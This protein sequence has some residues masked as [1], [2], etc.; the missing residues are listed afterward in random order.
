MSGA[1]FWDKTSASEQI[2]GV[3]FRMYTDRPHSIISLLPFA[4]NWRDRPYIIQGERT[5]TFGDMAN[6]TASRARLLVACGVKS[7]DRVLILGW[8]DPDWVL[9]FWACLRAGAIPALANTWWSVDELDAALAQLR[10]TLVLADR[11]GA[12]RIP[13]GWR[14]GSWEADGNLS[15]NGADMEFGAESLPDANENDPAAIIFT[16][17]TEGRAKAVVLAHRSLLANQQM[18]LHVT[19][20]LP[21]VIDADAGDIG[22]HTG[23]LFHIGGIHALLRGVLVGNTLVFTRGRFEPG[24]ALELIE[25][26]GIVRWSAV[27]TMAMRLL[28]HPDL[29]RRNLS[30]LRAMTIGGAPV[31]AELLKRIGTLLPSVQTSI[32]T[33][34]GLSENAG[35]ATT[36]SG[37]ETTARPGTA[38]RAMPLAELKIE[39]SPGL[40]DGE[41]FIRSPTQMLGYFGAHASPIDLDGWLHT[42][43][44]GRIDDAGYLWITGRSKDIIIR[45]GENIAPAAVEQALQAL[46]GV[47]DAAVFGIPHPDLGE[48]VMAVVVIDRE[49]T[50]QQLCDLIKGKVASFAVPSRWRLQRES[51]PVNQT[52]KVDKAALARREREASVASGTSRAP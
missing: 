51:L 34:Y 36:A 6:A 19:R 12:S 9:N 44:L 38:G 24:E 8:N 29:P 47:V 7:G 5:L 28:E 31:H 22:L 48:E 1:S 26:H 15:D 35:Q 40:V 21:Y 32:A 4:D 33:G 10:P 17:G 43:D 25:R 27:P 20:R 3:P 13:T 42:G 39:L 52:G 11:H 50:P 45:G 49:Q 18:I 16:S 14:C 23:P 2:G 46:P 30:S 41:V 37:S